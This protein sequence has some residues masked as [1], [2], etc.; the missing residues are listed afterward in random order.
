MKKKFFALLILGMAFMGIAFVLVKDA[1]SAYSPFVFL[2]Y[3]FLAA[4][5]VLAAIF[6]RHLS[7]ATIDTIKVAIVCGIPLLLSIIFQTVGLKY[8]SVSNSAFITG[9]VVLLI[10]IFKLA[11]Y[12]KQV[13]PIVWISCLIAACGL[14]I[15]TSRNG[16]TLNI[17]DLWTVACAVTLAFYVLQTGRFAHASNP[18]ARVTIIMAVCTLGSALGG[19]AMPGIDWLPQDF[20]FWKSVI[21]TALFGTV[22]MYA[23]QN[24]G[25][26][27]IEEEKV[28]LA[29]LTEPIFATMAAVLLINEQVTIETLYGGSMILAGMFLSEISPAKLWQLMVKTR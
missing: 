12:K 8:T 1:V 26:R 6:N 29:Y 23:V 5:I 2:F 27:F 7:Q 11:F 19:V 14:Y 20:E 18:M 25:Q 13:R 4:T 16:L 24:Y 10:P 3:R 21:F 9:M 15:I 28:A 17:G 22:Y